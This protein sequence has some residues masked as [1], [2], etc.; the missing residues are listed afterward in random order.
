MHGLTPRE[1][2]IIGLTSLAQSYF[3]SQAVLSIIQ[4]H[5]LPN[6][7]SI[8]L[9]LFPLVI[10]FI[11]R[12]RPRATTYATDD[13]AVLV[14][15]ALALVVLCEGLYAPRGTSTQALWRYIGFMIYM[16]GIHAR[17]ETE[18]AELAEASPRTAVVPEPRVNPKYV[19]D[20]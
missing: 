8:W 3:S 10:L 13:T 19:L 11:S 2:I 15:I 16:A 12:F 18:Q 9:A 7:D 5:P 1:I 17:W 20:A 6:N 14:F 4:G